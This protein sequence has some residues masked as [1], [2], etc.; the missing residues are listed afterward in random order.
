MVIFFKVVNFFNLCIC[1]HFV[2][3]KTDF[4]NELRLHQN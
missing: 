3:N 4:D 2:L 1:D